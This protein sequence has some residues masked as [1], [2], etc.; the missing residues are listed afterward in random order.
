[1]CLPCLL[2]HHEAVHQQLVDVFR[3]DIDTTLITWWPEVSVELRRVLC[4]DVCEQVML[5]AVHATSGDRLKGKDDDSDDDSDDYD[6]SISSISSSDDDD[7]YAF[8][9]DDDDVTWVNY[10]GHSLIESVSFSINGEVIKTI[11]P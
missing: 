10:L 6:D 9:D 4:K 5:Y 1:M 3:E 11:Y 8:N 7:E 2:R